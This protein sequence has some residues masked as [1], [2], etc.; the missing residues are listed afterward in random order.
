ME[1]FT[2]RNAAAQIGPTIHG[3]MVIW[4][5]NRL[6]TFD[7]YASSIGRPAATAGNVR[8]NEFLADPAAGA[9]V[10][11]DGTA[12]TTQDEFVE[13]RNITNVGLDISGFTL[14]D[15]VSVRH[16]FPA[17]TLLATGEVIVVFGGGT[18]AGLFGGA[19]VQTAS[20]GSLGLNNGGDTITLA[21]GAGTMID[22]VVYGG[23]TGLN[24]A[25]NE[26]LVRVPETT[27]GFVL[28]STDPLSG[29]TAQSPGTARTGIAF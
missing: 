6:G 23:T 12:S 1:L 28:H 29:G 15:S 3:G 11:G 14:S 26:S 10:N 19:S 9:D 4:A 22:S 2:A 20:A 18:P 7:L 13:L 21:D 24:G 27:G 8:I 25:N 16:T 17:G 5:D